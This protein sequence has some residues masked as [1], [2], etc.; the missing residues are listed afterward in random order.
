MANVN[1]NA[2]TL[3]RV[4]TK[5]QG[6]E[7]RFGMDAQ[8]ASN[9]RI[10]AEQNFVVRRTVEYA[11]VSGDAVMYTPEMK[12]LQAYLRTPEMKGGNLVAKELSRLLRPNFDSYPL[13]QVFVD[14]RITIHLPQYELKLWTPEGRMLAGV[15]CA[16]DFNE[17][18]RIRDRCMAG[19]E[20]ARKRGYCA[21]GGEALTTGFLWDA[22]S[23][24][25]SQDPVYLPPVVEAFRLIDGRRNQLP[26]HHRQA[27][28]LPATAEGQSAET[29]DAVL[30]A[31]DVVESDVRRRAG[32]Q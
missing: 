21:A 17:A 31:K 3:V 29:G 6:E 10:V 30:P 26:G 4:S 19:R 5:K 14:Q 23:K 22:K 11:D 12:H 8:R 15:L 32:D 28:I 18:E 9:A 27:A 2:V 13:L 1:R 25:Y 7:D 16:V 20:E 24:T